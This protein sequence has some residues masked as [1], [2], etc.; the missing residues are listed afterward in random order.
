MWIKRAAIA[1]F[2][3]VTAACTVAAAPAPAPPDFGGGGAV[4]PWTEPAA[5]AEAT[6][7]TAA[8][9]TALAGDE[10]GSLVGSEVGLFRLKNGQLSIFTGNSPKDADTGRIAAIVP[11]SVGAWVCGAKGLFWVQGNAIARSP[12]SDALPNAQWTAVAATTTNGVE[13]AW[14]GSKDGLFR[15]SSGQVDRLNIPQESSEIMGIGIGN[16]ALVVGLA[17]GRVCEVNLA[18]QKVACAEMA[19]LRGVAGAGGEVL[20]VDTQHVRL[21]HVDGSWQAWRLDSGEVRA[22]KISAAGELLVL[23][24]QGALVWRNDTWKSLAKV[25]GGHL[26]G[27][28]SNGTITTANGNT[29]RRFSSS[30]GVS[31]AKEIAP[32]LLAHCKNCHGNG[33]TAPKHDFGDLA[34]A[35]SLATALVQRVAI[36][37]MPPPPLPQLT[38][39]EKKLLDNWYGGGQHP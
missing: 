20:L 5:I 35:R 16:A 1:I 10:V 15:A 14:L 26:I 31:F 13:T 37:Q 34:T 33:A 12:V 38:S 30:L 6:T 11:R 3:V 21:R 19:G 4:L 18:D 22:A 7:T 17:S 23:T 25:S 32:I 9:V 27:G 8:N 24:D 28:E 29:L 39:A 36:G 2:A